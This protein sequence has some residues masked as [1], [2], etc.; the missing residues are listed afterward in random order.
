MR[1][2]RL[3]RTGLELSA[4]GL[5]TA[6]VPY[7]DPEG[8]PEVRECVAAALALGIN[9]FD[10]AESYGAGWAE[11]HLGRALRAAGCKRSDVVVSTKLYRGGTGPN[12]CGLSRK[13]LV[14]GLDASL[15]RLGLEHVD[16]LYCHRFDEAVSL[17]EIVRTMHALVTRGRTLYWGTSNW[18]PAQLRAASALARELGLTPPSVEQLE[19]NLATGDEHLARLREVTEPA[20]IGLVSTSPLAAGALA[21][22]YADGV[23]AGSLLSHPRYARLCAELLTGPRAAALARAAA[24][25]AEPAGRRGCTR[26]QLAIEYC[27]TRPGI[28][29]VLVGA[30]TPAQ[31]AENVAALALEAA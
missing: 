21:G 31:L 12:R 4:I 8:G 2:R 23:P 25:L 11:V 5:G 18:P 3:A 13:R 9:H 1:Y 7:D 19:V 29:S 24:A 28:A 6:R 17:D 15:A 22:T 27:V 14:E 10:T 26:A 16:I 30:R 20:G